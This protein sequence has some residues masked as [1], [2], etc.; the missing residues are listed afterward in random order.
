[1]I[2]LEGVRVS[3]DEGARVIELDGVCVMELDGVPVLVAV[4]VGLAVGNESVRLDANM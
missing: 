3:D 4:A 2:E 1:M